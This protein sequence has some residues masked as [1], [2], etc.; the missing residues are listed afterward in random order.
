M[1]YCFTIAL[2][3]QMKL[4]NVGKDPRTYNADGSTRLC[5]LWC[6]SLLKELIDHCWQRCFSNCLS[7]PAKKL[8]MKG[9]RMEPFGSLERSADEINHDRLI[10][11]NAASL[12]VTVI[13]AARAHTT[14]IQDSGDRPSWNTTSIEIRASSSNVPAPAKIQMKA[15]QKRYKKPQAKQMPAQRP[16]RSGQLVYIECPL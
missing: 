9:N 16:F 4:P 12:V 3:E 2:E 1:I 7:V 6:R 13:T 15:R 8:K 10:T 14:I 5:H 11:V